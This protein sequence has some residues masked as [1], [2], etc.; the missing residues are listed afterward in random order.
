M[1]SQQPVSMLLLP[2]LTY[3]LK[4]DLEVVFDYSHDCAQYMNVLELD[5]CIKCDQGGT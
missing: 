3:T 4:K 1:D 2:A 5:F